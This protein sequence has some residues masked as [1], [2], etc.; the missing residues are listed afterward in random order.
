MS[1]LAALL[2]AAAAP[3]A[4]TGQWVPFAVPS[5]G[6]QSFYDDGTIERDGDV[7]RVW[8]RWNPEDEAAPFH[9]A[10]LQSEIDCRRRTGRI[11]R[12]SAWGSDGALIGTDENPQEVEPIRDGYAAHAIEQALCRRP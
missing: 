6:G 1:L 2:L 11:L 7:V 3:P 8:V 4:P 10:R 9:E 5:Q 12:M